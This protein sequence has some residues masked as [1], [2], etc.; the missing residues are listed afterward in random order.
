[1]NK[2]TRIKIDE[3]LDRILQPPR[4]KNPEG[5]NVLLSLYTDDEEPAA[6]EASAVAA[7]PTAQTRQTSHNE[8]AQVAAP[9]KNFSKVANSIS[10][11]AVPDGWFRGKSKQLY[12]TLYSLTRGAINPTRSVRVPKLKLMKMSAI[13]ARNTFESN[14]KHL[15]N[16]GLIGQT[17]IVGEHQ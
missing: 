15:Q 2:K 17:V 13:G 16:I 8:S 3:T 5:L 11:Q 10:E 4:R 14:I 6:I 1:M 7:A 12:D 9:M